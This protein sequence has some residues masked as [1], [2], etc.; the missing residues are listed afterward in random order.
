MSV[1]LYAYRVRKMFIQMCNEIDSDD[2]KILN[3]DKLKKEYER[4]VIKYEKKEKKELIQI[5]N[6][7]ESYNIMMIAKKELSSIWVDRLKTNISYKY[8]YNIFEGWT[9]DKSTRNTMK[10]HQKGKNKNYVYEQSFT[11]ENVKE[12]FPPKNDLI[13]YNDDKA[14]IVRGYNNPD[15]SYSS[16]F[17]LVEYKKNI[18]IIKRTI[19]N[20]NSADNNDT[21]NHHILYEIMTQAFLYEK[22]KNQKKDAYT[23]IVIPKIIF[24]QMAPKKNEEEP[25]KVD[26]CMQ[27]AEGYT[28][29]SY[30][31]KY[32]LIAFAHVLKALWYLQTDYNFMHRDL[33]D[34]NVF[35]EIESKKVTFIDF[36]F[37]CVKINNDTDTYESWQNADEGFY[38]RDGSNNF[39]SNCRNRSFD[40]CVLIMS[41]SNDTSDGGF[42]K[43]EAKNIKIEIKKTY[44]K[45]AQ[46][47]NKINKGRYTNTTVDDWYPGNGP[48]GDGK[49]AGQSHHWIYEF[50]EF[51]MENWYPENILKRLLPHIEQEEWRYIRS[52]WENI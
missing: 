11:K 8:L 2:L 39:S 36:G 48:R 44:D 50:V 33:Y 35:Y 37:S 6:E 32:Q 51:P 22:T 7:K 24:V 1:A 47:K 10:N 21:D 28:L 3:I 41:L 18:C 52:N 43:N 27:R 5:S 40:A 17:T 29:S 30:V 26:I 13:K 14:H 42:F 15:G 12:E 46:E 31:E 38:K 19:G 16:V 20:E 25:T 45:N 9:R 49:N 23:H 4:K 34:S